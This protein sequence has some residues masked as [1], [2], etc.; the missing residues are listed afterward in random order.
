MPRQTRRITLPSSSPAA[1][2]HVT[3]HDYGAPDARPKAYLQAA[4]HADEIPGL[5]VQ[6]HLARR[7]DDADAAGLIK[8]RITLA[9]YANPIGLDQWLNW[10]HSG[11]HELASGGNFN[12]NWPDLLPHALSRLDGKLGADEAANVVAIREA[13]ADAVEQIAVD[14][15]LDALRQTLAREA[16]DADIVLDLHCDEDAL[17]HVY[18]LAVHWPEGEDLTR[19]LDTRV[20]LL[21]D[22]SGG[23]CFD[24]SLSLPWVR[25]AER[26]PEAPVPPACLGATIEL[27][28]QADV[29][30]ALAEADAEGL[31]RF[32]Q[33]RGVI[34]GDPGPLPAALCEATRLEACDVVKS[35]ATGVLSYRVAL[36]DRVATGQ[37]LADL[38]DP[39]AENP[40][41]GRRTIVSGTDGLVMTRQLH[42]YVSAGTDIAKVAGNERLAHRKTGD[43][44][45]P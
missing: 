22:D 30:D 14:S 24:E 28:G 13:L 3:F 19:N 11:R 9:P 45:M 5:L 29:S 25:L 7:L 17:M 15:E 43:L 42:K 37:P 20:V 1:S 23:G 2:R 21:S 38:I 41:E 8:G 12:R 40:A 26:F 6:H 44:M 35:P 4:I 18:L 34:D 16:V 39:A 32:L 36:G 33:H 10:N 27:R 31:F